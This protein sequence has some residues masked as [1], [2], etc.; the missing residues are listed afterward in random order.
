MN[1]LQHHRQKFAAL[2]FWLLLLGS[3][4]LYIKANNLTLTDLLIQIVD[5]LQT[6]L[7]PLVYISIYAIRPL[8]FLSATALTIAAGSIFGAGSTLNLVLAVI[9]SLIASHV[10]ASVAY[11][12]GRYFG[13]GLFEE[14][15][16]ASLIQTWAKRLRANTFETVL[17]MRVFFMP[18]DL[19]SYLAGF[20]RVSWFSFITGSLL[21]SITGT[22][23]FVSFGASLPLEAIMAGQRPEFNPYTFIFG[24]VLLVISLAI[25]RYFKSH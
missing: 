16:E 4:F 23:A 15:D 1:S 24:L 10:S 19:V 18:F 11:V 21:G 22:I 25:S 2:A 8:T 7:G 6:P 9:Y 17:L 5:L 3:G 14:N 12:V 20:L 13:A